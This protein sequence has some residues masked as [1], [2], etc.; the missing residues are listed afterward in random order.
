MT[1]VLTLN[2]N[3]LVSSGSV[4]TGTIGGDDNPTASLND[5]NFIDYDGTIRYSYS[6]AAFAN[7]AA[8][9]D[10]PVHDGLTAQGW[11]WTKAQITAQ[12]TAVPD[13]RVWVG[14][15]Y[16]TDDGKT[17]IK[18][19][20]DN[21]DLL[22]PYLKIAVNGTAVVDWGDN[23][24]TNTVTGTSLTLDIYTG[25]TYASTGEY[26]ITINMTS[27]S[28][29]FRSQ[30]VF[31]ERSNG[32]SNA[33]RRYNSSVTEIY[34]GSGITTLGASAFNGCYTLTTLTMPTAV[35]SLSASMFASC[36]SLRSITIPSNV[37]TIGNTTFQNNYALKNVSFPSGMTSIGNSALS[38]CST[39]QNVC[40]PYTATT[41]GTGLFNTSYSLRKAIIPNGMTNIGSSTFA[42]CYS[43]QNVIIHSGVTDIGGSAFNTCHSLMEIHFKPTTPPTVANSNA[44][45]MLPTDCKIYVP[46]GHLS[47]YTGA[48]NYPSSGT[49][50][51]VEE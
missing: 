39:L 9:P 19:R 34:L 46:A 41:F 51:Y 6:A 25:H 38:Y 15:Q 5:V 40:I 11:N 31:S 17:R 8:L 48:T 1:D 35:T 12:L 7:L 26:E 37:T 13:Q 27:G 2:G 43:L 4:L 45:T 16:I 33:S 32:T 23:T 10:N 22:S 36:Y 47:D 44:W 28:F 3:V 30:Y 14:Q 20:L 42:Y 29:T 24:S 18:L 49:Y 50:T 21:P